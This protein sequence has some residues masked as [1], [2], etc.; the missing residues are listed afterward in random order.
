[1]FDFRRTDST[2]KDFIELVALLDSDL[3][4]RDGEDHAFYHQFNSISQ[5]N[6]C[7]VGYSENKPVACGAIKTF[8]QIATEVKRM[9]VLPDFRGKGIATRLLQGL[10]HWANE[11]GY[12]YCILE[13]GKRQ[14]EAIA[15]YRKN[16]YEIIPNYGQYQGIENSVCFQKMV[17]S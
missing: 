13:T 14:P 3:A 12:E 15:L 11:L 4:Q 7:I 17:S 1:M 5:L 6:H 2:D 10:E 8:N 9:Y 16:G